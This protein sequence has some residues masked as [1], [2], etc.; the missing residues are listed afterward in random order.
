VVTSGGPPL[1]A[2]AS[3]SAPVLGDATHVGQTLT[4]TQ[5]EWSGST[6]MTFSYRWFRCPGGAR[7]ECRPID[8]A[9][10][11][12]YVLRGDDVGFTVRVLV[13]AANGAG[14]ASAPTGVIVPAV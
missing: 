2:P 13:A 7:T 3:V 1:T 14:H 4:S 12:S 11:P 9:D 5:G 6:P 10:D 8:G